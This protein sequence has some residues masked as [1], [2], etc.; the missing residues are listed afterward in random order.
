MP[1]RTSNLILLLI[2]LAASIAR[3]AGVGNLHF[4]DESWQLYRSLKIGTGEFYPNWFVG[5]YSYL[6]FV[7]Y[8]GV[9]LLGLLA[10]WWGSAAEFMGR[11]YRDPHILYVAGRVAETCA[12]VA[13]V[14][15]LYVLGKR[16]FSRS[17]GL[18]A[19]LFLAFNITHI[20]VSQMARGQSFA[21]LLGL[22]ALLCLERYSR[23]R[24]SSDAVIS[25][26]FLAGAVSIRVYY[27]AYWLVAG[28]YLLRDRKRGS[29]G[30]AAASLAG[31]FLLFTILFTPDLVF[32]PRGLLDGL[33]MAAVPVTSGNVLSGTE[34]EI[35]FSPPLWRYLG[36]MI[37]ASFGWPLYV[38]SSIG[39]LSALP[40]IK[41]TK[42][43]A[44]TLMPLAFLLV[45]GNS[46]LAAPRYVLP[47]FP[48]LFLLAGALLE[49]IFSRIGV[50]HRIWMPAVA[51]LLVVPG[52]P[53][54]VRWDSE[55]LRRRTID[56]AKEWIIDNIP[57]RAR[58][59]VES[60]GYAGPNIRLYSVIDY[61]IY[62]L[63]PDE[64]KA[65]YA[66][67]IKTD[68]EGSRALKYFIEH[69]P[70][71]W[72]RVY[73]LNVRH[74]VPLEQLTGEG[75]EYFVISSGVA[76]GYA[77]AR[78]KERLPD[79]V[80]NRE[81]FY[82]WVKANCDLVKSFPSSKKHPGPEIRVYRLKGG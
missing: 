10:G 50:S 48:L 33:T 67:R 22:L 31:S 32:A 71:P 51:A 6:M 7:W 82:E 70:Q 66:E 35:G 43:A 23:R 11:Y 60:T 68:P 56:L 3:L 65:L 76:E 12:G 52:I 8:S 17:V 30:R 26:I 79:L 55:L 59:A 37:P 74:P 40:R 53:G 62:R 77:A 28:I 81:S 14:Y 61:D 24:R 39:L 21:L 73:D 49:R 44:L 36:S 41:E 5:V 57:D 25:G 63:S 9:Y 34:R 75:V 47:A 18:A 42:F 78:T 4:P 27:L 15:C 38:L 2:L 80:A 69:P 16:Y 20:Q 54:I 29:L 19:S 45:M 64:L 72:H 13:G 46:R 1:K 58:I